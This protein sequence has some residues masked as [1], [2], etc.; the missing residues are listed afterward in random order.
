MPFMYLN[1]LYYMIMLYRECAIT[2]RVPV[3][4]LLVFAVLSVGA[5]WIGHHVFTRLKEMFA[6][7]V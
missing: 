4:D 5:F 1:P 2:G 6:E 7:H 3:M